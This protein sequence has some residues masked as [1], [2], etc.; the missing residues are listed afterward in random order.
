MLGLAMRIW[1]TLGELVAAGL[2]VIFRDDPD[3]LVGTTDSEMS[4]GLA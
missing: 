3:A 2:A 1:T 4:E